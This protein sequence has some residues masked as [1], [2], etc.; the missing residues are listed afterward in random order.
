MFGI[1]FGIMFDITI[2]ITIDIMF[3]I[4]LRVTPSP[5]AHDAHVFSVMQRV[6]GGRI[7]SSGTQGAELHI[8]FGNYL[9]VSRACQ[10][11]C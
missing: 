3:D 2:D 1:M 7:G 8:E 9:E 5:F 11:R 6:L 4:M 10:C